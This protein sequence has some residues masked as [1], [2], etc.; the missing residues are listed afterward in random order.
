M[1]KSNLRR[2][3]MAGNWKMNMTVSQA[4]IL[5]KDIVEA[6][7]GITTCDIVVA[8]SFVCL[9]AVQEIICG[10][11]VCLAAQNVF[12]EDVGAFTGEISA[13]MLIDLG[14]TY[15]IVGHSERRQFFAETNET[16]NKR[17][18]QAFK[19]K[20]IPIVCVGETLAEREE[21]KT[22]DVVKQQIVGALAGVSVTDMHQVIVAYEPVWAIGTGKTAT[23]TQANDVHV[24]IRKYIEELYNSTIAEFV[25]IQY[26]GSVKP[27]NIQGL[28]TESSIDGALIGGASLNA[29]SFANIVKFSR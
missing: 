28:M 26:G 3:I 29:E 16:V 17:V 25:R 21:G 20:L 1:E 7:K 19:K 27:D 14:V 9:Q 13:D 5:A 15:V 22:C 10:T 4:K 8:P 6:V 12:W 18:H 11:N 23:N 2:P 24:A